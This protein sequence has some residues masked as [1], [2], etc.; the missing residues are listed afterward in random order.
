[1]LK[2]IKKLSNYHIRDI[3]KPIYESKLSSKD[4]YPTS[5]YMFNYQFFKIKFIIYKSIIYYIYS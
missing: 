4:K 5:Y 2:L 1:V 3:S